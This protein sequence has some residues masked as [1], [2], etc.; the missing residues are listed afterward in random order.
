MPIF[1]VAYDLRTPGQDY[2]RLAD[3]LR[4]FSHCHMQHSVWLVE[5]TGPATALRDAL[6]SFLDGNDTLFVDEVG[7]TWAGFRMKPCGDWLNVRGL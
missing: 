7:G 2:D 5:A 6:T 4:K 1:L 3:E